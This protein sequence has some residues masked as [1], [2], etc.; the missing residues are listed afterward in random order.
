MVE[1]DNLVEVADDALFCGFSVGFEVDVVCFSVVVGFVFVEVEKVVVTSGAE[2]FG[3]ESYFSFASFAG[4]C[5]W[6]P[7]EFFVTGV[8]EVFGVVLFFLIAII[9]SLY[10]LEIMR[11]HI[12]N[13][14]Q[15]CYFRSFFN[16]R[17]SY[18]LYCANF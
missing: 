6:L 15:T 9:T 4:S 16:G 3:V 17:T 7:F 13:F 18:N 8:A 14:V 11:S 10:H 1:V 5:F 2:V 12:K